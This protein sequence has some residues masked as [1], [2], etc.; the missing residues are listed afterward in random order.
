MPGLAVGKNAERR[1]T[2][3]S[4]VREGGREGGREGQDGR[5]GEREKLQIHIICTCII[6]CTCIYTECADCVAL[7]NFNPLLNAY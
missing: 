1:R 6:H 7:G 4:D 2:A 5:E 3:S